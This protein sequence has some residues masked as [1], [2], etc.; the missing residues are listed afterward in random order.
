MDLCPVNKKKGRRRAPKGSSLSL[1]CLLG[2]GNVSPTSP[3]SPKPLRPHRNAVQVGQE[4]SADCFETRMTRRTPNHQRLGGEYHLP[5]SELS[6]PM[7]FRMEDAFF[8]FLQGSRLSVSSGRRHTTSCTSR[9]SLSHRCRPIFH[10]PD[11]LLS[12]PPLSDQPRR[13]CSHRMSR[14]GGH[15]GGLSCSKRPS[16]QT[17]RE[18]DRNK[19][20]ESSSVA[21]D[22]VPVE[23]G[24]TGKPGCAPIG[25][26][27][28]NKCGQSKLRTSCIWV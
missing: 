3:P 22:A 17:K 4:K 28:A 12:G 7:P 20:R 16:Q 24:Q 19:G 18:E 21:I 8:F 1:A 5:L 10:T 11:A 27:L 15:R 26:R 9:L 14:S 23:R 25:K 6:A 2:I 13:P